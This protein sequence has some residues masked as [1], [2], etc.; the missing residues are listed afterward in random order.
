MDIVID[1]RHW[2]ELQRGLEAAPLSEVLVS[3]VPFPAFQGSRV[4]WWEAVP[5][6][7]GS[8]GGR[9]AVTC[10]RLGFSLR[11]ILIYHRR[12]RSPE[13]V[14]TGKA[15]LHPSLV[16]QSLGGSQGSSEQGI[17]A[18]IRLHPGKKVIVSVGQLTFIWMPRP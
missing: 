14:Q 16:G 5:L 1:R 10:R 11:A 17:H 18:S 7:S 4:L 8:V 13:F 2:P 15:L 3:K 6:R 9:N 12:R